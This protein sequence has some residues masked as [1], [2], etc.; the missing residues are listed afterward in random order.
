[1]LAAA[2]AGLLTA[3]AVSRLRGAL[4]AAATWLLAWL[5]ALALA[6]FPALS[7]GTQGLVLPPPALGPRAQCELALALTALA[8]LLVH[9]IREGPAGHRLALL[10]EQPQAALAA[11]V[12]AARLRLGCLAGSA[13]I[14]GLAGGLLVQL[15]T[16]ADPTAYGP[17]LSFQLLVAVLIGGATAAFGG[18]AGVGVLAALSAVWTALASITP[19]LDGVAREQI[20]PLMTALL[21]LGVLTYGGGGLVPWLW[22]FA[23]AWLLRR[24][25]PQP[26]R[27][28]IRLREPV[29][30]GDGVLLRAE[31][32]HRRYG[33]LVVLDGVDVELRAG[34]IHALV[35]PNGSGKTTVLRLLAARDPARQVRHGVVRTLQQTATAP[36][37]DGAG[38]RARRRRRAAPPRRRAALRPGDAAGPGRVER[39]PAGPPARRS[40][41]PRSSPPPTRPPASSRRPSSAG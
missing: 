26:G 28:E 34:R 7:G 22:T 31:G 15:R 16:V 17:F 21:L 5:V 9:R 41:S 25:P 23:P 19:G 1:M 27:S 8:A 36:D 30:A 24:A 35:G 32:L 13:A 10:R 2:A 20:D 3:V 6:A 40:S 12:P 37:A 18:A 38:A 33:G 11:G 39:G 29:P 4:A 14:A